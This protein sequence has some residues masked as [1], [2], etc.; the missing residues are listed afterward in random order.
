MS[1]FDGDTPHAATVQQPA[2]QPSDGWPIVDLVIQDLVDR[3]LMGQKKY[4]CLLRPFNGR[5]ALIDAYQEALDH[6]MYLRQF[7]CERDEPC[8]PQA[9]ATSLGEQEA[10]P[11]GAQHDHS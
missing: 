2:P 5:D 7:I 8:T 10:R 3:A 11:I 1:E 4:G 6:L 9:D